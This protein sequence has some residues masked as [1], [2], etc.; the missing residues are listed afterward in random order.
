M[1]G[2]ILVMTNY[3][4]QNN[5]T[6]PAWAPQEWEIDVIAWIRDSLSLMNICQVDAITQI[7][8]TPWSTVLQIPTGQGMMFF[9]AVAPV[10]KHEILLSHQL[11]LWENESVA[12]VFA[13]QPNLG[14]MLMPD[15]GIRLRDVIRS[16][17]NPDAW[18]A[19]LPIYAGLQKRLTRKTLELLELEVPDRR[20]ALL[21]GL[22]TRLINDES[23]LGIGNE[24]GITDAELVSLYKQQCFLEEYC[25][26]LAKIPVPESLN[27]GDFHDGNIFVRPD[28]Y[29][30][31]D[32]GDCSLTHP[33][34]SLRTV[35]VS[36]EIS[37]GWDDDDPRCIPYVD[38]Y[39]LA[40]KDT[41]SFGDIKAAYGVSRILAPIIS[42][43]SWHRV[44]S[45]L[46][47]DKR[48]DYSHAV[49]G[50]LKEFLDNARK[51]S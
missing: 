16:T 50:L 20:L 15:G 41:M 38:R 43:L 27:H 45:S 9:K 44:V 12:P 28:G 7:H 1:Y 30:F 36:L 2:L 8:I 46:P 17:K 31:F 21:P 22:F 49:P 3:T 19:V 4:K 13:V 47:S 51:F 26:Q 40:W 35:C 32:W 10:L 5:L 33:F 29:T 48:A 25:S 37:M 6:L 24:N 39:L 18:R 42:A 11:A 34:F 14:W 23:A